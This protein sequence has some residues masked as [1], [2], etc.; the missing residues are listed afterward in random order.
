MSEP[1]SPYASLQVKN[2]MSPTPETLTPED[3]LLDADLRMRRAGVRHFPV[4]SDGCLVGLLSERDVRRYAASILY[5]TPEEYNKTF[6]QT[7]AGTVMS[8]GVTT[9]G[10][11]APLAEAA[12]LLYAQR[13]GCLPVMDGDRLVGIITRADI[14]R[15]ANDVLSGAR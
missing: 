2:Y 3:H 14:L 6:E 7:L 4:V 1:T 9:V 5:S 11:E 12:S 8:K 13:L 15:F 10:P